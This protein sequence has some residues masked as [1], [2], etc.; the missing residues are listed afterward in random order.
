[1][2]RARDLIDSAAPLSAICLACTADPTYR[3]VALARAEVA[4]AERRAKKNQ[5]FEAAVKAKEA[6]KAEKK[7]AKAERRATRAAEASAE[8]AGADGEAAVEP[9]G[10]ERGGEGLSSGTGAS[11][12]QQPALAEPGAPQESSSS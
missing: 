1:M 7:V 6:A 11:E 5:R 3:P 4:R 2:R 12:E 8:P 9:Q 10:E